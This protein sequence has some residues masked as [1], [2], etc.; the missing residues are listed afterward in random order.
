[1]TKPPPVMNNDGPRTITGTLTNTYVATNG[2]VLATKPQDLSKRAVSALAY[3]NGGYKTYPGAGGVDGSFS[4]PNAP[5]GTLLVQV[6]TAY[7]ETDASQLNSSIA[8]FGRP[9]AKPTT[10]DTNI[11]VSATQM[12]AWQDNDFLELDCPD[13]GD[14]WGTSATYGSDGVTLTPVA[15]DTTLT[16]FEFAGSLAAT[17]PLHLIEANRGDRCLLSHQRSQ[18]VT[19]DAS[20]LVITEVAPLMPFTTAAATTVSTS[21]TFAPLD[22]K[23]EVT[24][25]VRGTE[26]AAALADGAPVGAQMRGDVVISL[27]PADPH[28]SY[29][30]NVVNA[31]DLNFGANIGLVPVRYGSPFDK[32]YPMAGVF[33]GYA[34]QPT[35]PGGKLGDFVFVNYFA[36]YADVAVLDAPVRP[37]LGQVRSPTINGH[38][39]H[40]AQT[41]V[42]TTPTFA[43]QP[44]ALGKPTYYDVIIQHVT[45]DAKQF[46]R[47]EYVAGLIVHE[48]SIQVPPGILLAGQP[49][50][51]LV[52]AVREP[53]TEAGDELGQ[54]RLPLIIVD[55]PSQIFVP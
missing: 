15:G 49:Y 4:I 52:E 19:A 14:D 30:L 41:G 50:I 34:F 54:S 12:T 21:G 24:L 2:A 8:R 55:N 7:V 23:N 9:D 44:P 45:V 3:E 38:D 5:P 17:T 13:V 10:S 53:V 32:W 51:A 18:Q 27:Q 40:V 28:Q 43:W 11:T 48:T 42:G 20:L 36:Q 22:L 37:E 29:M 1:M 31:M 6:G 47:V 35:L 46:T 25:D 39:I 26:L 33:F 16:A